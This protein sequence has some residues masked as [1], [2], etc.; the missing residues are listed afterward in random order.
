MNMQDNMTSFPS[1]CNERKHLY[2]L[3][4]LSFQSR[5]RPHVWCL[6]GHFQ[7]RGDWLRPE[8]A[9]SSADCTAG[10]AATGQL[11][12]LTC[13]HTSCKSNKRHSCWCHILFVLYHAHWCLI[14]LP[15]PLP[16]ADGQYL[17]QACG[18]HLQGGAELGHSRFLQQLQRLPQHGLCPAELRQDIEESTGDGQGDVHRLVANTQCKHSHQ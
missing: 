4:S 1:K 12:D 14:F 13:L 18:G 5:R 11:W 9:G 16:G 6:L 7:L 15:E 2:H 10:P 3:W 17:Q 8:T